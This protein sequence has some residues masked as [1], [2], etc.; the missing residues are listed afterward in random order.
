MKLCGEPQHSPEHFS[1]RRYKRG[2]GGGAVWWWCLL[3]RV[4]NFGGR[5]CYFTYPD[6]SV[7][8]WTRLTLHEHRGLTQFPLLVFAGFILCTSGEAFPG[9]SNIV[10]LGLLLHFHTS[11]SHELTLLA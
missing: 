3:A 5:L 8:C 10:G 11:A 9:D 2:L 1:V 7:P 6:L 4:I